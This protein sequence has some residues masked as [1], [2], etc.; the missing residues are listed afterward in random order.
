MGSSSEIELDLPLVGWQAHLFNRDMTNAGFRTRYFS[1]SQVLVCRTDWISVG[2]IGND[3]TRAGLPAT[4][5]E[6]QLR[7]LSD[8]A[9]GSVV[10][11]LH[12]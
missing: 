2:I 7:K 10:G 6:A 9:F 12:R 4:P 5:N 11:R 1:N 3:P 8:K